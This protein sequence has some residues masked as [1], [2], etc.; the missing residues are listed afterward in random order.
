MRAIRYKLIMLILT[1]PIWA[2]CMILLAVAYII[3]MVW[4]AYDKI[5]GMSTDD[6]VHGAGLTLMLI[7]TVLAFA[8]Q[9][10]PTE[11]TISRDTCFR[12]LTEVEC[13]LAS[14]WLYIRF[15]TALMAAWIMISVVC[16]YKIGYILWRVYRW[17]RTMAS[18]G[19][20]DRSRRAMPLPL[21]IEDRR[22]P[23]SE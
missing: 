19:M 22:A 21:S 20:P 1:P 18:A 14:V 17:S 8:T 4:N 9:G 7:C 23:A 13:N 6:K 11:Q 3:A 15:V 12:G 2:G 10:I 5:K 16:L